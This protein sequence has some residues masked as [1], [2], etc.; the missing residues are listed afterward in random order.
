MNSIIYVLCLS[1]AYMN[2]CH[3]ADIPC[4]STLDSVLVNS[5]LESFIYSNT[6]QP[7]Y[8]APH[9]SAVFSITRS[10]HGSQN[11]YFALCLL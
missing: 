10:C 9:Y 2:M 5:F 11:D 8:N 7:R 3:I 4:M 1:F 6:V